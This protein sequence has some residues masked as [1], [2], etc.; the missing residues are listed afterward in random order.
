MYWIVGSVRL[1]VCK[2]M[3][4]VRLCWRWKVVVWTHPDFTQCR[5]YIFAS[6]SANI[7]AV[8]NCKRTSSIH[9]SWQRGFMEILQEGDFRMFVTD[10]QNKYRMHGVLL[11]QAWSLT[12][13]LL[14]VFVCRGVIS[15]VLNSK[16]T[17]S[18]H[19]SWRIGFLEILQEGDF[20]MFVTDIQANVACTG[21]LL[22]Q[23]WSLTAMLLQFFVC[24]GVISAVLNSKRT[25]SMH[26]SWRMVF[27]E[28]LQDGDFR[29][30]VRGMHANV[31][32]TEVLVIQ[33][34]RLIAIVEDLCL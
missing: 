30:L 10:T 4:R 2:D 22:I 32:C 16:R 26:S 23:A 21:V 27:L 14:Q 29:M 9:S 5:L 24:R 20:R 28:I 33:A 11:I 12:A 19:S 25:L 17:L 6:V 3:A 1:A 7:S 18:I 34:W 31:A 8:L 15:A 13:M